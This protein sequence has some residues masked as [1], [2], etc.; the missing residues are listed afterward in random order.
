M[1]LIPVDDV[2]KKEK[3]S[4]LKDS[5]FLIDIDRLEEYERSIREKKSALPDPAYWKGKRVLITG[6]SGMVG[7][8]MID[9]LISM[10]AEVHGTIKR[11]AVAL[12]PNIDNQMES[13]RLR[14]HEVDLRDYGRISSL[15]REIEPHVV[16]HQAAESFVPSGISMPSHV[17]E[18]NCVSTVNVLEACARE[19]K[20]LE[21]VQVACSSEQYGFIKDVSELPVREENELRPT[22]TYAATK[23]FT[24]YIAKSY[25]YTYRTPAVIT[26]TFNQEGPRRGPQFFTA[27]VASQIR[28]CAD[29]KADRIVLGNPNSVRDFTHV[30]DSTRAQLLAIERCDRGI[31]YNI[32]SGKGITTGDYAKLALRV[33]GLE[34]RVPF[35][36]DKRLLRP[37]ERGEAL[38]DGFIGSNK[39]ICEKTGWCPT[40]TVSDIIR[41]QV[42]FL[43]KG[44]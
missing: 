14:T 35:F 44:L 12:H 7:S 6:A 40:K 15:M 42:E 36:V 43:K 41:D 16:S 10:G 23:V 2:L 25:F 21:A 32:C 26:R 9:S 18:N 30:L 5:G 17:V 20:S 3:L 28:R 27:R 8:T 22:S 1:D 39:R 4:G 37:Y 31:A 34:G 33:Y 29:G 11:H 19:G 24:E 38:F 13:G